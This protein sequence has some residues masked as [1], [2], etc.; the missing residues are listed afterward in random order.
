ME[1][2]SFLFGIFIGILSGLI[3]GLHSNTV[4]VILSSFDIPNEAMG[5][6][7]VAV[8]SSHLV[9]SFIPSIFFGI[10]SDSSVVSVLPGQR[11]VKEGNG[12]I[13]LKTVL[14]SILFATLVCIAIFSFSMDAF[15]VVY[16][17][18]KPYIGYILL[19]F[20]AVF[21]LI[22]KNRFLTLCIFLLAGILGQFS[23]NL[24]M[25]DVF[26]PLFS[27]F[28]AMSAIL[29]YEKGAKIPKQKDNGVGIEI[30]GYALLGVALGFFADLLPGIGAPSQIAMLATIAIPMNSLG[31]LAT[32][33]SISASE[34]IFSFSTSASIGKTRMGA[35]ELLGKYVSIGDNLL[36]LLVLFLLS[37]AISIAIIYF[38]RKLIGK[39]AEI[40]FRKLNILIAL[41]LVAIIFVL[42]GT[43]GLIVLALSSALG[44]TTVKLNVSRT[45]LMSA[46]IIPTLLLLFRI[47]I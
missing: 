39:I 7:I 22:S 23:L 20:S 4:I 15:S 3:P 45:T 12:I 1:S 29:T 9:T 16:S 14:A 11:M 35:T 18:I 30:F 28:F 6:I 25:Y 19:A 34:A 31:Y 44:Y 46:I 47:F 33:S 43:N 26:L 32:I 38:A 8:F 27:G 17:A 24:K 42:N 37:I 36:F 10:P 41:Y 40:D 13:A 2:I 5:A 21:I